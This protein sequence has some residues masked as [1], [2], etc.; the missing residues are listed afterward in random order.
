MELSTAHGAERDVFAIPQPDWEWSTDPEI[1][2]RQFEQALAARGFSQSSTSKRPS[3]ASPTKRRTAKPLPPVTCWEE[4]FA[5]TLLW[6]PRCADDFELGVYPCRREIALG[7]RYV[8][9]NTP[10]RASWLI[11]DID[12]AKAADAWRNG[13]LPMPSLIMENP[14]NGHA[15]IAWR[16]AVA[17]SCSHPLSKS[18]RFLSA[19]E[20]GYTRRIDSDKAFSMNGLIKNALHPAW[21]VYRLFDGA[22]SLNELARPLERDEMRLWTPSERKSGLGRNVSL[23]DD[24]RVFAYCEVLRFKA[25][26][27]FGSYSNRLQEK[28]N[29]LN[30][31][32]DFTGPLSFAELRGIIKSVAR[33][34]WRN[35][36]LERFSEIQSKRGIRGMASRWAGHTSLDESRPWEA[37]GISRRTW[38]RRQKAPSAQ[39]PG[40][41]ITISGNI[42]DRGQGANQGN[43]RLVIASGL[44]QLRRHG[45]AEQIAPN[46][47]S[48]RLSALAHIERAAV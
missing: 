37:D 3:A 11:S 26:G 25:S 17:V 10:S 5:R 34:T 24:L 16:L 12:R 46:A 42:G 23:F 2:P 32:L 29:E 38:F 20:R 22:Y 21:R 33:F 18:L 36:R 48:I 6:R 15:H 41:T 9:Y 1:W 7:Y 19:I 30:R 28:A 27:D 45:R 44:H 14:G 4:D 43:P 40:G 8:Q 13:Q 39:V 35:F 47:H 31:N